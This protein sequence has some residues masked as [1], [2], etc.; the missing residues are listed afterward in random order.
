MSR[1]EVADTVNCYL[2][3]KGYNEADI[4]ANYVGKLE[5]G[6]HRWP[7][8][9]RREAFRAVLGAVSDAALGF[10]VVRCE[11]H[12]AADHAQIEVDRLETADGGRRALLGGVAG[13]VA[14]LGL[15]GWGP[16]G[17]KS[18]RIGGSD[19]ARLNAV[20]A[21]YR[22]VDY[23]SGGG[24]LRVEAGRFAEAASSLSDRPCNDTVKPALLA[25]IA[26]A[27]QLAGWAAFDTGHHSDAQRYWLSAER[28]A[29][30][31][32]DLRLAARVRYCQARQFQHLR[33]NGDALDTL[34]LAREHLAGGATPAINAMLHGAEAASLAARGDRQEALTA[35]GAATDAFDRIDPDCEPE[36]MR[37]YD[38]GELLAQYGRVYR[39][40]AR[41]DE[42]H[43]NAA[44]QWVTEAIAAFGASNVRSTVL[45]EVGLCSGLFLAAE[46]H[47]AVTVGN[48]VIQHAN[49]LTSQRVH[50]RI[51]NLRRDLVPYGDDPE[52]AEFS[53]TLSTIGS[54]T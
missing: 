28:T 36:W 50:D 40:L 6:E 38:R 10:Y 19:V 18:A 54:G 22:S 39:D 9:S 2:A 24:V 34:R 17:D 30:A 16:R 31:A 32:G 26:N 52:V 25:A 7:R 51:R 49:Q 11:P 37:F 46:P 4:D 42:R 14:A 13:L 48:R 45:N 23:E 5:R 35:L 21:L 43:G 53:R 8:D 1:Q 44:V 3:R 29:V 15:F 27:R 20:V 41:S 12:Q 33:H 47:E